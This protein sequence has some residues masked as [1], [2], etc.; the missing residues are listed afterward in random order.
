M[1]TSRYDKMMYLLLFGIALALCSCATTKQDWQEASRAGT[2][3]AY[4][5]FLQKHSDADQA[6]EARRRLA[7]LRDDENWNKTKSVN[8]I[9]GYKEFLNQ[10]PQSRHAKEA[11]AQLEQLESDRDWIQT[12]T[13]AAIPAY[14]EF[15][16]KHPQSKYASEAKR[17]L[18]RLKDESDWKSTQ[19][20]NTSSAYMAFLWNHPSSPHSGEARKRL[21]VL[22]EEEAWKNAESRNTESAWVDFIVKHS[23]SAK[24]EEAVK[25]LK[26]HK[27]IRAGGLISWADLG[28]KSIEAD[29]T[30]SN[31]QGALVSGVTTIRLPGMPTTFD[32]NDQTQFGFPHWVKLGKVMV[33]GHLK[34]SAKGLNVVSGMALIPVSK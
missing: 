4:E 8:T 26:N 20:A 2:I 24:A 9:A 30:F 22:Q 7:L 17:E 34:G 19:E 21:S 5:Q 32:C 28:G 1:T 12:K 14:D 11:G 15:L 25:K 31:F 18:E 6:G 29:D 23:E 10:Y 13:L 3:Q 27:V 33:T 16:K